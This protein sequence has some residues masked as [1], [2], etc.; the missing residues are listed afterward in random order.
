MNWEVLGSVGELVGA[1][2][3]VVSLIYLAMQVRQNTSALE[4]STHQDLIANQLSAQSIIGANPQV[5]DLMTRA[6]QNY[7]GLTEAEHKQFSHICFS[8]INVFQSA[9]FNYEAG[10]FKICLLY[11]SPSPRDPE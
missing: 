3:V 7:D 10:L 6:D 2:A 11:T 5:A 4:V 8:L 9:R 1:L